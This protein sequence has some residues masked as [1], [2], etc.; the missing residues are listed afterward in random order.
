MGAPGLTIAGGMLFVG[1]GYVGTND[2]VPGNALL[3]FGL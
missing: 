3:A 2:G 1:S